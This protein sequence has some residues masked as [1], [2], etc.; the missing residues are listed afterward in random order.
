M[1][2]QVVRPVIPGQTRFS[3]DPVRNRDERIEECLRLVDALGWGSGT[4]T[5]AHAPLI[6]E[7]ADWLGGAVREYLESLPATVLAGRMAN[8]T[9]YAVRL[10]AV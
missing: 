1:T 3:G 6:G 2:A 10:R 4:I 7:D 9:T 8:L 5:V